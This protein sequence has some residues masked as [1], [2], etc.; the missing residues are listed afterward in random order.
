MTDDPN[1]RH[2]SDPEGEPARQDNAPP[3]AKPQI[4]VAP[5]PAQPIPSAEI[6]DRFIIAQMAT[7][8]APPLAIIGRCVR[9]L[10]KHG[11]FDGKTLATAINV[12]VE[13][14]RSHQAA[15]PRL[16]VPGRDN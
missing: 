7:G 11:G 3:G 8:G 10:E 1:A 13:D 5:V 6:L 12:V 4:G 15:K 16:I 2:I 9:M 14:F